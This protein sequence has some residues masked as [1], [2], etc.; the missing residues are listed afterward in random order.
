MADVRTLVRGMVV[1]PVSTVP[2]A[3][4]QPGWTA[5]MAI[6]VGVHLLEAALT[7][8][9]FARWHQEIRGAL[10][11]LG[12]WHVPGVAPLFSALSNPLVGGLGFL[13]GMAAYWCVLIGVPTLACR[14]RFG[15]RGNPLLVLRT[16][17]YA[18]VLDL[19]WAFGM[20]LGV[21]SPMGVYMWAMFGVIATVWQVGI[22]AD[23]FRHAYGLTP[24]QAFQAVV[25][26]LAGVFFPVA[27]LGEF[28]YC[29]MA[30]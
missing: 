25:I 22:F 23:V 17:G 9:M 30:R 21:I 10:R 11:A 28:L 2:L 16:Y 18:V 14:W 13:L 8:A 26:G 1:D 12:F 5:P 7:A 6:F 3:V 4:Q 24:T 15:V 19:L 20:V 27:C 29:T